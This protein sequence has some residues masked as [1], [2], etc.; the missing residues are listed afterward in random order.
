MANLTAAVGLN[1]RAYLVLRFA[2][3]C[4]VSSHTLSQTHF[5]SP[6]LQV[7]FYLSIV[8]SYL[9]RSYA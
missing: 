5:L 8:V 3:A 7:I 9:F 6:F 1:V 2:L 4:I